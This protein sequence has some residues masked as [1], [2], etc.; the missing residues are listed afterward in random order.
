MKITVIITISIFIISA[1]SI[2]AA[3]FPV[4]SR[5]GW[6]IN[7]VSHK[8]QFHTGIDIPVTAGTPIRAIFSGEVFLARLYRGYGIAVIL[9][10][11]AGTYTLYGHCSK[12][13]VKPGQAVHAGKKIALAGSTGIST[14]PHL[15]LEYW[16]NHQYVDPMII[17]R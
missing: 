5:F 6:R 1:S 7:P 10:H 12:V 3:G 11:E 17:W 16:V 4:S 15:H 2:S 9:R 14:G 13:L 8:Q